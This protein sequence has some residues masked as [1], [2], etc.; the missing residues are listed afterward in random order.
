[1]STGPNGYIIDKTLRGDTNMDV[2]SYV[3]FMRPDIIARVRAKVEE[4][5]SEDRITF[6]QSAAFMRKFETA[7]DKGTYLQPHEEVRAAEGK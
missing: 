1:V 4:A 6:E 3:Q 5:L 7:L 2:L